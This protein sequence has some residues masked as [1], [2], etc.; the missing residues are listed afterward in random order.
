MSEDQLDLEIDLRF[1]LSWWREIALFTVLCVLAA[2]VVTQVLPRIYEAKSQVLILRRRTDVDFES[3]LNIETEGD[4]LESA[5]PGTATYRDLVMNPVVAEDALRRL[6]GAWVDGSAGPAALLGMVEAETK[7]GSDLLL[8]KA[9]NADPARAAAV[10]T[11]WGEAYVVYVN[12]LYNEASAD[13]DAVV[14][15]LSQRQAEYQAA[16]TALESFVAEEQ[17]AGLERVAEE[18][19]ALIDRLQADRQVALT[20]LSDAP[21]R[22]SVKLAYTD[23]VVSDR[24]YGSEQAGCESLV[25]ALPEEMGDVVE[26]TCPPTFSVSLEKRLAES[27]GRSPAP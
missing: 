20:M 11:A 21:G 25:L 8:I 6:N 9:R 18:K 2:G 16:Q 10:A 15:Q 23:A 12:Q 1:L 26:T 24:L 13:Y 17:I 5:G 27:R 7:A 4:A 14:T 3:Q 19:V 22:A